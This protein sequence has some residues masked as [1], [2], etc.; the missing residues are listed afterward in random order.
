MI[1]NKTNKTHGRPIISS[2]ALLSDR[3]NQMSVP[4]VILELIERFER[5]KDSYCS[6]QYKEAQLREEFIN[7]FF[8]ELGIGWGRFQ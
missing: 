1:I 8:G 7:P 4:N 3:M 5:N 6:T 2:V